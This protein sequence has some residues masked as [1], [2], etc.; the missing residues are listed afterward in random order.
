LSNKN[1]TL[2][3]RKSLKSLVVD[4][5]TYNFTDK[6]ALAYIENRLGRSIHYNT[7]KRVQRE[8]NQGL[9]TQEFLQ[10]FSKVGFS[11][12]HHELLQN[13]LNAYRDTNNKIFYLNLFMK[14]KK[15]EVEYKKDRHYYDDYL[16]RL[17]QL[18][19]Q[20]GNEVLKYTL[21]TPVIAQMKAMIRQELI[22]Q[23]RDKLMIE[24]GMELNDANYNIMKNIFNEDIKKGRVNISDVKKDNISSADIDNEITTHSDKIL[25]T[26]ERSSEVRKKSLFSREDTIP[27]SS[28]ESEHLQSQINSDTNYSI[29]TTEQQERIKENILKRKSK[30]I[31]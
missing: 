30:F 19:M 2:E 6:E 15:T 1:L 24:G 28:I 25:G 10:Q 3:Q 14:S 7:Y 18:Q 9:V 23:E 29:P 13:S 26:T 27:D 21:G 16:I 12:V 20:Q 17:K 31:Y 22:L 8:I 11:I 4:C 5:I